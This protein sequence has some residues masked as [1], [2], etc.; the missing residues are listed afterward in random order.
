MPETITVQGKSFWLIVAAVVF[1]VVILLLVILLP[2]SFGYVNYYEYGLTR[3]QFTGEVN[4][5]EFYTMGRHFIGVDNK[6]VKFPATAQ[7]LRIDDLVILTSDKEEV[8]L[9]ITFEYFI[10]GYD[11]HYLYK[12]YAMNYEAAI[13]ARARKAILEKSASLKYHQFIDEKRVVEQ[14]YFEH[15]KNEVNGY[16]CEKGCNENYR[17]CEPRCR[18]YATCTVSDKGMFVSVRYMQLLGVTWNPVLYKMYLGQALTEV[19]V[20][21]LHHDEVAS[22]IRKQ[23]EFEVGEILNGVDEY[24]QANMS[25]ATEIREK[26]KANARAITD[27]AHVLGMDVVFDNLGLA[28]SVEQ[29]A[30]FLYLR[31]LTY[32]EN[33]Y[34]SVDFSQLTLSPSVLMTAK[35]ANSESMNSDAVNGNAAKGLVT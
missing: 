35:N 21:T 11:L 1:I 17:L 9:N 5:E 20:Q 27:N 19:F 14:V 32:M 22:M 29:K 3:H 33:V 18:P 2:L 12:D 10:R 6:F 15:L 26:A 7:M 31:T 8:T 34:L 24:V 13:L 23:T 4:D 25:V 28:L 30:S 16:C